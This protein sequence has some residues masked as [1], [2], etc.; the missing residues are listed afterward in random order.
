MVL[1]EAVDQC[2]ID[3]QEFSHF[4]R[5]IWGEN[6]GLMKEMRES[7]LQWKAVDKEDLLGEGKDDEEVH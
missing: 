3:R 5:V 7:W 4:E 6:V 1:L 2:L